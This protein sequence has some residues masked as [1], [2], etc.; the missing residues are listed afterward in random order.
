[1]NDPPQIRTRQHVCD[2]IHRRRDARAHADEDGDTSHRLPRIMTVTQVADYLQFSAVT[3][4]RLMTRTPPGLPGRK[5]GGGWRFRRDDLDAFIRTG[6]IP[7]R[8]EAVV[9]NNGLQETPDSP[10]A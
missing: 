3:I 1:M 8:A 6:Q 5:I 4:Y 9:S 7:G 10:D 2:E